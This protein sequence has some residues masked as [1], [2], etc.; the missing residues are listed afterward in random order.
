MQGGGREIK[1]STVDTHEDSGRGRGLA[2]REAGA[3]ERIEA[4]GRG[5][6]GT[7]IDAL[8]EWNTANSSGGVWAACYG[9][10]TRNGQVGA[11]GRAIVLYW[12]GCLTLMQTRK[13][14]SSAEDGGVRRVFKPD[15]RR[16]I[17]LA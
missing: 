11:P 8:Q 7:N 14:G 13:G 4:G 2:R 3:C 6:R 12:V 17:R 9:L 10:T 16:I 5:A 15:G 1:M